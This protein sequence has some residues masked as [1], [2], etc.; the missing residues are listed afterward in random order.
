[1][2]MKKI[3]YIE[4]DDAIASIFKQ[5][6][7]EAGYSVAR[8]DNGEDGMKAVLDFN[9]DLIITG[10]M[11]PKVSGFD[12]I[13]ILKQ[14]KETKHIPIMVLSALGQQSDKDRALKLG[15]IDYMVMS[16]VNIMDVLNR[17]NT[18]FAKSP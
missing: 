11:M 1:M 15:V 5:R 3:L 13:D 6:F 14:T 2:T 7:E 10:I 18:C 17:V 8:C 4:D 9:P 12:V 16:Q